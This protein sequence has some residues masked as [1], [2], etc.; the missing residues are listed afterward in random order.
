MRA[1]IGS[2]ERFQEVKAPLVAVCAII[3]TAVLFILWLGVVVIVT[4]LLLG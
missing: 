2:K 1:V 3:A 4:K